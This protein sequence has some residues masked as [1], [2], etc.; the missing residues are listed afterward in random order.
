[1][2][3]MPYYTTLAGIDTAAQAIAALKARSLDVMP[4]QR[5]FGT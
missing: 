3:K 1:M 4:L 2:N 5:Y